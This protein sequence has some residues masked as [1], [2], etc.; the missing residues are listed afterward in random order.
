ML[1]RQDAVAH[2][3]LPATPAL[4]IVSEVKQAA[5]VAA[6]SNVINVQEERTQN[7]KMPEYLGNLTMTKRRTLW[8]TVHNIYGEVNP[9]IIKAV[10]MANT[11]IKNKNVIAEGYKIHLPSIPADIKPINEG[12]IIVAVES[13]KDLEIV[14]NT[15]WGNP[16]QQNMPPLVFFPFWNKKEG[17]NFA[18]VV[19]KYFKNI[20]AAEEAVGKLPPVLAAKTKIISQWDADT[21]FFNRRKLQH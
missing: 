4:P 20:R 21:V 3:Q 12:D 15:F 5:P 18:I 9:E 16:D 7:V 1:Q 19:D 6:A 13:G 14:Y 10:I 8:W 2:K 17:I 11:H